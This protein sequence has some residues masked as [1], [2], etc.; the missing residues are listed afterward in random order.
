[1]ENMTWKDIKYAMESGYKS[2]TIGIGSVEQHGPQLPITTDTHLGDEVAVRV[3]KRLGRTLVAPTIRPGCSQHHMGF[4]GTISLKSEVLGKIIDDYV[5]SLVHHDFKNMIL[6]PTHGGNFET[7]KESHK[8]LSEKYK[9]E[10]KIYAYYNLEGF[11]DAFNSP[12]VKHGFTP[13]QAGI[14]AG[15]AETSFMLALRPELVR[16]DRVCTGW[17]SEFS[18]EVSKKIFE[19]GIKALSDI[20]VLGDPVGSTA[21]IGTEVINAVV[22]KIVESLMEQGLKT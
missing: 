4:P 7:V 5:E 17:L 8:R 13:A 9:E 20:G 2:V 16:M 12:A 21:D 6:L 3:A 22:E 10:T 1:M 15:L 18:E 14:H 11:L 19:G